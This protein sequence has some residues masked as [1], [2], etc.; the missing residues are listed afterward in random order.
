M[1]SRRRFLLAVASTF[2][3][4]KQWA[5]AQSNEPLSANQSGSC[6]LTT[7]AIDGPY[8]IDDVFLRSEISEDRD[9]VPLN[10]DLNLVDESCNPL[11]GAIV[12]IWHCDAQGNYSGFPGADP[13]EFPNVRGRAKPTSELVFCRGRQIADSNGKVSF[14]TI[15]PGWYTPRTVHIHLKAFL[16]EEEMIGTQLYFPQELNDSILGKAAAYKSRGESPYRNQ[17]DMVIKW[18]GGSTNAWPRVTGDPSS[19]IIGTHTVVVKRSA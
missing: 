13:D 6:L 1:Q 18:S 5:W 4:L 2:P 11:E 16:N 8:Y 15:Y 7:E 17:G 19:G 10:L 9:G 12:D 14:K 3:A